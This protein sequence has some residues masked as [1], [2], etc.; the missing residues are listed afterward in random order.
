V[1]ALGFSVTGALGRAFSSCLR[2]G[3][4][5]I[6]IVCES[7]ATILSV[8][9]VGQVCRGNGQAQYVH[10]ATVVRSHSAVLMAVEIEW[11]RRLSGGRKLRSPR[12][13]LGNKRVVMVLLY[14]D[15]AG[16]V[17]AAVLGISLHVGMEGTWSG[18]RR[19]KAVL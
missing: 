7:V 3:L 18:R 10:N 1:V 15:Y 16:W 17:D 2:N 4:R 8:R 5:M 6:G 14:Y 12:G 9:D 13:I 11:A 19:K